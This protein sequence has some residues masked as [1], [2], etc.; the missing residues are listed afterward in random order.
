MQAKPTQLLSDL[1]MTEAQLL[2]K[3]HSCAAKANKWNHAKE[4]LLR[5]P[6]NT[7]WT[8]NRA[9]SIVWDRRPTEHFQEPEPLVLYAL[10]VQK[11]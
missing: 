5:I 3:F 1:G 8:S 11:F 6:A 7:K 4:I 9:L 2:S 10:P